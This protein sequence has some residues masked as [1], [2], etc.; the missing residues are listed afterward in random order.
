MLNDTKTMGNKRIKTSYTERTDIAKIESNWTKLCG[1]LDREEWSSAILRAA[2]ASEIAVNLAIR[3]EL[4][5][6]R[7][8]ASDFVDSLLM[9]ANGI[10]GKFDHLLLP[11]TKDR[12]DVHKKFQ[13]K[14][15]PMVKKINT[16]RNSVAH[17]GQFKKRSTAKKVALNAKEVIEMVVGEYHEGFRLR[18]IEKHLASTSS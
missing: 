10:Q 9:W 8:L 18:D 17:S 4:Q 12:T 11:V 5:V 16:E 13:K 2:T 1:L 3:E 14:V 15:Y 7:K 6:K